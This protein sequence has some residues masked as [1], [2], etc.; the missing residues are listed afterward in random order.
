MKS[1][2]QMN[3]RLGVGLIYSRWHS[4]FANKAVSLS[5]TAY[6]HDTALGSDREDTHTRTAFIETLFTHFIWLLYK[7]QD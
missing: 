6:T 4:Q 3:E 2:M 7:S 5:A 1:K